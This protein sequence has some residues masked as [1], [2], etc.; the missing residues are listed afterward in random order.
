MHARRRRAVPHRD[1]RPHGRPGGGGR[2]PPHHHGLRRRLPVGPRRHPRRPPAAGGQRRALR[3]RRRQPGPAARVPRRRAGEGDPGW[4]YGEYAKGQPITGI[5]RVDR[6]SCRVFYGAVRADADGRVVTDG[7]KCLN[8]V[9][10][11]PTLED[12]AAAAYRGVAEIG[13][14]GIRYR[15]DIGKAMPWD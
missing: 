14:P 8:L 11:G 12:A 10:R 15:G 9:G 1:Q 13:F 6:A 2:L 5:E 3:Q 4:P 7:G